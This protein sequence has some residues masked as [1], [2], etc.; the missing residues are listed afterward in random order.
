MGKQKAKI[1][2]IKTNNIDNT[3]LD[4]FFFILYS[5]FI[6]LPLLFRGGYFERE[7]LPILTGINIVF[8]A[9]LF[10]KKKDRDFKIFDSPIEILFFG[11][12]IIYL[13]SIFYGVSKRDSLLEFIKYFSYFAIIVMSKS[14]SKDKGIDKGILYTLVFG[15]VL[16]SLIGI[17]S[18]I[19]T[20]EYNGAMVGNRLSST[21]Q[22]PNTLAAY[23]AG[24]YFLALTLLIYED[25]KIL[26]GLFGSITGI[27]IFS[28]ILTYSRAMWL[29]FPISIILYF[30]FI[31]NSR[32]LE[33]IIYMIGS[34][35]FSIPASFLF[36]RELSEPSPKL[37]IYVFLATLGTGTLIYILSL[38][39]NKYRQVSV[40]KLIVALS[41]LFILAGVSGVYIIATTEI[42]LENK[43]NENTWTSLTRNISKTEP[44]SDYELNVAYTGEN[45]VEAPYCGRVVIYNINN[46][47]EA[48]QLIVQNIE[49]TGK[50]EITIPFSTDEDSIGIGILFQNL[51]SNTGITIRESFI[52]D[53]KTND[54]VKNIPLKYKY[55]PESI[56]TRISGINT[57]ESS[58]TARMMFNK[59]G[60][61]IVKNYPIFGAGGGGWKTLYQKYQSTPYWTTLAHNYFLQLC[62]EIGI[63]GLL[64]MLGILF[65]ITFSSIKAYKSMENIKSKVFIVGL[66]LTIF[67]LLLHSFVDFDMFM[68]SY[69]II[70]W[71]LV[72]LLTSKLEFS[73]R[74]NHWIVKPKFLNSKWLFYTIMTLSIGLIFINGS[75]IL[76]NNYVTNA[77]KANEENSIV[78]VMTNF[79]KA[80]KFDKWKSTSRL[81]LANT[82]MVMFS[83]T[84]DIEYVRKAEELIDEYIKLSK[85]SSSAC[86]NACSFYLSIGKIEKGLEQIEKSIEMQP[87]RT[88]NYTQKAEVY[89]EVFDYYFSKGEY[90]LAKEALEEGLRTKVQIE[91]VNSWALKPLKES[92]GFVNN[93]GKLKYNNKNFDELQDIND[94]GNIIDFAYYFDIDVNNDGNLDMLLSSNPAGLKLD[95]EVYTLNEENFMRITNNEEKYGF[96]YIYPLNL[97]PDSD[98]IV[99]IKTRGTTR[100]GTF[101][102]YAW[103]T[104]SKEPNQ[105]GLETI[106]LTENWEIYSFEFKTDPDVEPGKQY[107]RLQ[108]SG[109]DE[110][111][112][113][114][115]E[116]VIFRKS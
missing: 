17:G 34:A 45:T 80:V 26:K 35:F 106:E 50:N 100:P 87:L 55:I 62:V 41:I 102:I 38:L 28:L 43:G 3:K 112:I 51:Y 104:S 71:V 88:D 66:Y 111:H 94:E 29:M 113:D 7:F 91:E 42:I 116:L 14:L 13:L 78:E 73:N 40:K 32:K 57:G 93:Y 15:G 86:A 69:A 77:E 53:L 95:Y 48:K 9:Y 39:D 21:F 37:W 60:L 97:E 76:S 61:K 68:S 31:P 36:T 22:Y 18:A 10:I 114:I 75:L 110:G 20:W 63:V 109:N 27:L 103:S 70:V 82:Y 30:I 84:D 25:N 105:G 101:R 6:T 24:L 44:S 8:I 79:E 107:I 4:R 96:Y 23:V 2:K 52:T 49:D 81:N 64:L 89:L 92:V 12:V 1:S 11:I 115:K 19:G 46:K 58:F 54:V 56:I 72:A 74:V 85:Y 16:V 47:G 5:I 98:Y 67:T 90:N 108:H 83:M 65:L 99:E 59:D 33:S